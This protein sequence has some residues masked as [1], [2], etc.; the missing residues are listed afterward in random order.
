MIAR[1]SAPNEC[2]QNLL[3]MPLMDGPIEALNLSPVRSKYGGLVLR[4]SV[5]QPAEDQAGVCAAKA[6]RV[7][8]DHVDWPL[9]CGTRHKINRSG[10]RRIVQVDRR[11]NDLIAH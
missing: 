10:D 8:Q 3:S 9:S 4:P 1:P 7:R 11:R 6:E 5:D 2:A